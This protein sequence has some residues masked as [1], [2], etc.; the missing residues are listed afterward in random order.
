MKWK[1]QS[2]LILSIYLCLLSASLSANS[3]EPSG[4]SE[5]QS[6]ELRNIPPQVVHDLSIL[7]TPGWQS[8]LLGLSLSMLS[9]SATLYTQLITLSWA[10]S[11]YPQHAYLISSVAGRLMD[12][13]LDYRLS[14]TNTEALNKIVFSNSDLFLSPMESWD[15]R[16]LTS[17]VASEKEL[18]DFYG[19]LKQLFLSASTDRPVQI[20]FHDPELN[21]LTNWFW[22]PSRSHSSGGFFVIAFNNPGNTVC[23]DIAGNETSTSTGILKKMACNWPSSDFRIQIYSHYQDGKIQSVFTPVLNGISGPAYSYT[24]INDENFEPGMPIQTCFSGDLFKKE[25]ASKTGL[26]RHYYN[27][28]FSPSSFAMINMLSSNSGYWTASAARGGVSETDDDEPIIVLVNQNMPEILPLEGSGLLRSLSVTGDAALILDYGITGQPRA[29]ITTYRTS[30]LVRQLDRLSQRRGSELSGHLLWSSGINLASSV[31]KQFIVQY[32]LQHGVLPAAG[33]WSETTASGK[34]ILPSDPEEPVTDSEHEG[35]AVGIRQCPKKKGKP[36]AKHSKSTAQQKQRSSSVS[37]G[38]SKRATSGQLPS[39]S[40]SNNPAPEPFPAKDEGKQIT[41]HCERCGEKIIITP[42]MAHI[43]AVY[44]ESKDLSLPG[45]PCWF[46]ET[47]QKQLPPGQ[48]KRETVL[49]GGKPMAKTGSRIYWEQKQKIMADVHASGKSS[50]FSKPVTEKESYARTYMPT[51]QKLKQREGATIEISYLEL[52][53]A[54]FKAVK[55]V[56]ALKRQ[57][58]L[59][60]DQSR[61]LLERTPVDHDLYGAICFI[62]AESQLMGNGHILTNDMAELFS[63]AYQHGIPQALPYYLCILS[64]DHYHV[65]PV[66]WFDPIKLIRV[67]RSANSVI[68]QFEKDIRKKHSFSVGY[69]RLNPGTLSVPQLLAQVR[70]QYEANIGSCSMIADLDQEPTQGYTFY[71]H[72]SVYLSGLEQ[73][74]L[75]DTY[76][77]LKE[78]L[79]TLEA[80]PRRF[81]VKKY[82]LFYAYAILTGQP[83]PEEKVVQD[84]FFQA[85]FTPEKQESGLPELAYLLYADY[86][87]S[88]EKSLT[89]ATKEF[90]LYA[91]CAKRMH[92]V[93]V[94]YAS[95]YFYRYQEND[96]ANKVYNMGLFRCH[97]FIN[98]HQWPLY[99]LSLSELS[100]YLEYHNENIP[101]LFTKEFN[102]AIKQQYEGAAEEWIATFHDLNDLLEWANTESTAPSQPHDIKAIST[103][104]LSEPESLPE[105]AVSSPT[106]LV[107]EMTCL[108]IAPEELSEPRPELQTS[109]LV[110]VDTSVSAQ[111]TRPEDTVIHS[112]LRHQPFPYRELYK[113][114]ALINRGNFDEAETKLANI[115][116]TDHHSFNKRWRVTQLQAWLAVQQSK[117]FQYL[118]A[119]VSKLPHEQ[120]LLKTRNDILVKAERAVKKEINHAAKECQ[121]PSCFSGEAPELISAVKLGSELERLM[122]GAQKVLGSLFSVLG[123]LTS[124]YADS[125]H[126]RKDINHRAREYYSMANR[127]RGWTN[128]QQQPQ[129][130]TTKP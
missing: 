47:C 94:I 19:S 78:L 106:D 41:R 27:D 49:T 128:V 114:N 61:Q 129:S 77:P 16:L 39:G 123:H 32:V 95:N 107:S 62:C 100:S 42:D 60:C 38:H 37:T 3:V 74:H 81:P 40:D 124:S 51:I 113:I 66:K 15:R 122:P 76:C 46:C 109:S 93:A 33:P 9:G 2:C 87:A 8:Q 65:N 110:S 10:L 89:D 108:Q 96:L 97:Q 59:I 85:Q 72:L 29:S 112:P 105:E 67:A 99:Y 35:K 14:S 101:E 75:G 116:V 82:R 71:Y 52:V 21:T 36:A 119:R 54:Q 79:T 69:L 58:Q 98:H 92:P 130:A 28:V 57:R 73:S 111:S 18:N 63:I 121:M 90:Y 103:T 80:Q 13:F 83:T 125:L 50:A 30:T 31:L 64:G 55:T 7:E 43:D 118:H 25:Q 45:K 68:E 102:T 48:L 56:Q 20:T 91:T 34:K 127:L 115:Q 12:L 1:T 22:Q 53:G 6:Y 24:L 120:T 44:H 4:N 117:D 126:D 70:L 17:A 23:N 104:R 86:K 5:Q 11:R 88:M 84:G 26:C